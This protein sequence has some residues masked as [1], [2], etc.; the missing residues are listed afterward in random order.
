MQ[1]HISGLYELL[2]NHIVWIKITNTKDLA[3]MYVL[4]CY[5]LHYWII[6]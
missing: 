1:V 2:R 6:F 3:V 4:S 5:E